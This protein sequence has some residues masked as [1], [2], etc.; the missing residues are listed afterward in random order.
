[1]AIARLLSQREMEQLPFKSGLA[2]NRRTA[3][4]TPYSVGVWIAPIDGSQ[5]D[6]QVDLSSMVQAVSHDLRSEG[7][8]IL[9]PHQVEGSTFV[10]AIPDDEP[11]WRFFVAQLCHNSVRPGNWHHL[12]VHVVRVL[13]AT[14]EQQRS[15]REMMATSNEPQAIGS[16]REDTLS[17]VSVC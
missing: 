9:T 8:G 6:E 1:M 10:I 2:E 3:S 17:P 13:E 16:S 11:Q 7:L 12:G 4:N 5:D 15:F 14:A